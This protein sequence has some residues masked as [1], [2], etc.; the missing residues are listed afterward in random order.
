MAELAQ[1]GR[2]ARDGLWGV[3]LGFFLSAAELKVVSERNA[4]GLL[5]NKPARTIRAEKSR[6]ACANATPMSCEV[7]RDRWLPTTAV[8][9]GPDRASGRC[10]A[11]SASR[12]E[13][14]QRMDVEMSK[15]AGLVAEEDA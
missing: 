13:V 10:T 5:A 9:F 7:R 11:S 15:A 8:T 1:A 12:K 4:H 3:E 6:Q 14:R 2:D